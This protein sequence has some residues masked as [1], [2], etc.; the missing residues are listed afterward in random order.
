[1]YNSIHI[2]EKWF[3]LYKV[4]SSYVLT[5]E[6]LPPQRQ[7]EN[8][9]YITKVMF[10]AAVARPRYDYDRKTGFDGKLGIFPIVRQRLAKRT[11]KNQKAGDLI[12]EALSVDKNVYRDLLMNKIL[13]A[14][15]AKWPGT[16]GFYLCH[17]R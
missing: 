6:E 13:P 10:I 2:D 5:A 7:C 8:K 16:N 11:T 12:T 14:I 4:A 9:R 1:M 17:Y 3:F 15:E